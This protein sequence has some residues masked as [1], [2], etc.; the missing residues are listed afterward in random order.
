MMKQIYFFVGTTAELLKLFPVIRELELRKID[1]KIITSGQTGINFDE[2]SLY[3]KKTKADIILPGKTNDSSVFLFLLWALKT[4]FFGPFTLAKE[5]RNIDKS[6]SWFIVHGDTVSS[7]IGAIIAKLF[8]LRLVHIESGL[9]SFDFLDP[10]PE[11][12]TRFLVAKLTDVHF[13]PNKWSLNNLA[14]EGGAKINAFQNTFIESLH[15][16]LSRRSVAK[17]PGKK[18]FILITHRQEHVIFGKRQNQRQVELILKN[19]PRKLICLFIT[20]ST[21]ESFLKSVGFRFGFWRKRKVKFIPRLKYGEFV[22]LL[23]NAQFMVSD[24]GGN[25]EEAYY[26]GLPCLIIREHTERREGLGE[27]VV[28]AQNNEKIIMDFLRNY[29]NYKSKPVRS[30]IRPSKVIV[31]Y[32]L[33]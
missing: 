27:N 26:L 7:L 20:H 23:K 25:Q 13:C 32:L 9:R 15:F 12:L 31:D 18:Y 30:K 5:F 22:R 16:A 19:F 21:T 4:L 28:L 11:E 17:L 6:E 14:Q 33:K 8:G 10:F 29:R 3:I 2:V 1:F 24:G